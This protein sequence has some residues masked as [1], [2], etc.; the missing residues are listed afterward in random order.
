MLTT[1]LAHE[2]VAKQAEIVPGN[3]AIHDDFHARC[4]GQL[5][6]GFIN[7]SLLQPDRRYASLNAGFHDGADT[8]R[9]QEYID[10]VD[11]TWHLRKLAVRTLTQY[12]INRR[13][14]RTARTVSRPRTA[15]ER[16][17]SPSARPR[18]SASIPAARPPST[19]RR[20]TR[21]RA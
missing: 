14:L 6:S 12:G 18:I 15:S 4:Q 20:R 1:H 5:G 17:R 2:P 3:A 10:E 8:F 9:R 11:S 7:H 16:S 21:Q 19:R 13:P